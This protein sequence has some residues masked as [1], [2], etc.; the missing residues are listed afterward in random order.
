MLHVFKSTHSRI[1]KTSFR[2]LHKLG[3]NGYPLPPPKITAINYIRPLAFGITTSTAFFFVGAYIHER[4]QDTFWKK[5]KQLDGPNW[6]QLRK[7]VRDD[8]L[9]LYDVWQEKKKLWMERKEQLLQTIR[10]R[11]ESY[12]SLPTELKRVILSTAQTLLSMPESEKTMTALIG[13]NLAVFVAWRVPQLQRFLTRSFVATTTSNNISMVASCF[14]HRQFFHLA[15]NMV[16]LWSFGP[17][18]HDVL[19]REQFLAL[20]LS[21]GVSANVIS[22]IVQLALHRPSTGSLGA[23][24]ALY[25]ILTGT[26]VLYPQA[27]VFV[28]FLPSLPIRIRYTSIY[29]IYI[30]TIHSNAMRLVVNDISFLF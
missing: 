21:L 4:E 17:W 25:G 2:N 3:H 6:S 26:A 20:Y 8:Q 28:A 5:L 10:S 15:L 18:L 27:I 16:A 7:L 30:Y 9:V 24:G 23:S 12:R 14:S 11:L 29:Y 13:I 22:R 1:I 19:G